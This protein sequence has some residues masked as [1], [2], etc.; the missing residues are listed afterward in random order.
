MDAWGALL[1]PA[2]VEGG[3]PEVNLIPPQVHQFRSSQAVPV[4]HQNHCRVPVAVPVARGG[5]HQ[6]FDLGLRQVFACAQ[7]A[8]A[9]SFG[10][11]CLFYGVRRDQL[12][13]RF[14]HRFQLP[15]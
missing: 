6:P 7:V 13:M 1:D 3:R 4:G 8:V 9:A 12:K 11:N 15:A 14:D 5:L 2:D 10:H